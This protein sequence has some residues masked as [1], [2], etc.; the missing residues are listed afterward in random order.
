[1]RHSISETRD[2]N[3]RCGSSCALNSCTRKVA[4]SVA[5]Q[6]AIL[7]ALGAA[8][9]LKEA[10]LE[11]GDH[12]KVMGKD[13]FYV[14]LAEVQGRATLRVGGANNIEH[15]TLDVPINQVVSLEH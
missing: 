10:T 15:P 14:F 8:S 6:L 7:S 9:G 2:R 13:G 11:K 1:M 5:T 12:V 3:I 4:R